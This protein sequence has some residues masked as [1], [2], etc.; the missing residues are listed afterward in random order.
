MADDAQRSSQPWIELAELAA[1]ERGDDLDALIEDLS[2]GDTARAFANLDEDMRRRTLEMLPLERASQV[3]DS[4]P[5]SQA[6]D[7]VELLSNEGAAAVLGE[8]PSD[9]RADLLS[10]IGDA[11]AEE[12]LGAMAPA[13]ASVARQFSAYPPDSAGGLMIAEYLHYPADSRFSDVID[14][15]RQNSEH[16]AGYDVQYAY[17]TGSGDRLVG[18][19]PLREFV[20]ADPR[21]VLRSLMIPDP[22][23]VSVTDR[24]DALRDVFEQTG[25]VGLPV[26][27]EHDRLI[28]VLKSE[29]VREALESRSGSDHLKTQ[30]IIGG[31]ELRTMPVLT[32]SGRRLSWLS[33]NILLNLMAASVIAVFQETVQAVIALAV[34]LPIISDMSGCSGNQAVAV[35]LRELT[36]GLIRPVDAARVWFKEI[37]VGML[38]GLALGTLIALAA[39]LWKGNPYLGFVVGFALMVNTMVAVSLGGVIPLLLR[40]LKVDPALAS[41]PLLTTVT[42]MCGFALV[43]GL[44]TLML[45][46]LLAG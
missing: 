4:V 25:F 38:N 18:V 21:A 16:Y 10:H 23:H 39:F 28:G 9:R 2:S 5:E 35:S 46:Q 34:F 36:L 15:L 11:R 20:L 1:G 29:D 17:E 37:S 7:L 22:H 13:E 40:K 30:G 43:L 27:D 31:E 12:I 33:V 44:A 32:R 42:D 8:L 41:G 14:D 45:P 24:L 26:V 19:V 6:A 3:L